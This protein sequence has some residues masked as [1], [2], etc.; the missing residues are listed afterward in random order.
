MCSLLKHIVST[1]KGESKPLIPDILNLVVN[2][3]RK[4]PQAS[5]LSLSKTA[6]ILFGRDNEYSNLM[7]QLLKE[8]V[9]ITLQMCSQLNSN[10]QLAEKSDV[11]EAFFVMLA[12]LF[13]KVPPIIQN[14][15]IDLGAVFQCGR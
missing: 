2:I 5:V 1:L 7:Q 13:K 12:Q 11:L 14:S 15:G 9:N 3:Y 8:I 10:T 6:M 4:L